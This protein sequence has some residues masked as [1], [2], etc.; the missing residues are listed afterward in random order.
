[1]IIVL[2]S[3]G[4]DSLGALIFALNRQQ[5]AI[6]KDEILA[7]YSDLGHRYADKEILAFTKI[8][9]QLN[10]KNK[11][12]HRFQWLGKSEQKDAYIPFRNLFLIEDALIELPEGF[13]NGF[14]H[15]IYL[16]NV[17][18]GE[19]EVGDRT[20]SFNKQTEELINNAYNRGVQIIS[21][22]E[23]ST[24]GQI[25]SY[26]KDRVPLEIIKLTVGCFTNS[27]SHCGKCPACFRRWVA[28][29]HVGID[30]TGWFDNPPQEWEGV[31]QYA[32]KMLLGMYDRR[33]VEETLAVLKKFDLLK[34][35]K[36][37]AVDI[38]GVLCEERQDLNYHLSGPKYNNITK[39]N[40][41]YA[42]GHGIMLYSS[43]FESDREVTKIWLQNYGV[44]YHKLVLGK[45]QADFYVDDRNKG[46]WEL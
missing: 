46:V 39:V 7:L 25:V 9:E 27:F 21:P 26:L 41:L 40:S 28:L 13:P 36:V 18:V 32:V 23:D 5:Y 38:D 20:L 34:N 24:K 12:S 2:F 44:K 6:D 33:R 10:V 8:C 19:T 4:L 31:K 3:G 37:Y 17:Q 43:R 30:T 15:K 29:E 22:F 11:I 42:D 14:T 45:P 35:V 1:M 16:Q